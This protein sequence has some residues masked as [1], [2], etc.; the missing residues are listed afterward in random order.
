MGSYLTQREKESGKLQKTCQCGKAITCRCDTCS[1]P[2]CTDCLLV[3]PDTGKHY[4]KKCATNAE[5]IPYR[6]WDRAIL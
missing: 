1:E 4:C 5:V 6:K 3:D 2:M